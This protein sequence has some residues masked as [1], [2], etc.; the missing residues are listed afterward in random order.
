MSKIECVW[1]VFDH[2]DRPVIEYYHWMEVNEGDNN[3]V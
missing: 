3:Y 2:M 1:T